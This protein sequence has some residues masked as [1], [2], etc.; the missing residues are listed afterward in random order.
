VKISGFTFVRNAILFGYP[1]YESLQSLLPVCDELVVATGESDDDTISYLKSFQNN[2][3]KIIET[4]W[5][6]NL[7]KAG[8]VYSQQT[9]IALNACKGDWCIYLQADEVL[10]EEDYNLFIDEIKSADSNP[11]IDGLLF[12]Y[13]HFY[14][15]YDYIG[16]GRQWYRREIRAFRNTGNVISWGDAQGFRKYKN[17][18]MEKLRAKQ[19]NIKVF[20]YGWVKPPKVQNLKYQ[21][22][23]SYYQD[24]FEIDI[25]N[26]EQISDFDY[27]SAYE[28]EKFKG[29]HPEIMKN[30][31]EQDKLWTDLFDSS[32]LKKKPLLMNLSD[33]LEKATG[34][35]IGEFK[36]FIEVK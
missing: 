23:K 29:K 36:D 7:H 13:L 9:N 18:K 11:N 15:S 28:L 10:H 2:K 19:T 24:D 30:R 17:G 33:K 6:Q 12:H 32:R 26:T 35:R 20:H 31:I 4:K 14:G 8:L 3:I 27:N 16:T 1:I 5:D 22:T 34:W 25:K 21:Y